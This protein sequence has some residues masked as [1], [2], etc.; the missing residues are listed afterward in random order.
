I[1]ASASPRRAELL[2]KAGIHVEIKPCHKPE[3]VRKP[4]SVDVEMW[5]VCLAHYKAAAV[6]NAFRQADPRGSRPVVIGADTIVE[7]GGRIINK[8]SN[9]SHAR[10]IL[11]M[12]SGRT[13]CVI[14]GVAVITT[15]QTHLISATATC[16]MRRLSLTMLEQ[17][18]AGGLWRGKA[19]AYGIQDSSDPLVELISG[20]ITTVMGLPMPPLLE[21]LHRVGVVMR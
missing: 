2:R 18:I 17:Y 1:L 21:L 7:L 15:D 5:P 10:D 6:F 19:G 13:H 8:V 12:L 14:T 11:R 20:D 4:A 16:R 9:A 3:P